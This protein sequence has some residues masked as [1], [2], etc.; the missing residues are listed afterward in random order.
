MKAIPIKILVLSLFFGAGASRANDVYPSPYT[1]FYAN[2]Q[3]INVA[4]VNDLIRNQSYP[5]KRNSSSGTNYTNTPSENQTDL[6]Y[7]PSK[8]RTKTNLQTFVNKSRAVDPA[9]AAKLEAF[10][11][12]NDVIGQIGQVMASEGMSKN[13]VADAFAVYWVNA[14]AA[15]YGISDETPGSTYRAVSQ[16]AARGLA[17]SPEF[18]RAT[19][20][21]KQEMAEALLIQGAMV[22]AARQNALSDPAMLRKVGQAVMQG[23][24]ATGLDLDQMTLTDDGFVKAK[25]TG[26]ASGAAAGEKALAANDAGDVDGG[27]DADSEGL[28]ATQLALIA[29]AA[30]AGLGGVFLAGKAMGRRG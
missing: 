30:G 6:T 26:D 20:A 19:D 27:A 10:V 28:S 7:T 12:S 5:E 17:S 14:W 29:A 11:G 18:T 1:D 8:S 3:A 22:D 24:K 15:A 9:G 13:N 2:N 21:Q 16:Q 4:V 23:A 25:K